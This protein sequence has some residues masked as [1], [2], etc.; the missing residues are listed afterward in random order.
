[1]RRYRATNPRLP[2]SVADGYYG[3][4]THAPFGIIIVTAACHHQKYPVTAML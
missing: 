2:T 1:L 4:E 3:W